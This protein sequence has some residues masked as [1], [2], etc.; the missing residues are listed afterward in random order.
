[1]LDRDW[2]GYERA[3]EVSRLEGGRFYCSL[4]RLTWQRAPKTFCAGVPV[5]RYGAWPEQLYTY[6]Q[7]RRDLHMRPLDREQPQG[8]Y[9]LRKSPYR[10]WLYSV[11]QSVPRRRMESPRQQ[12][13]VRKMRAGL[14]Q[15]YTCQRCGYYDESHGKQKYAREMSRGWCEDC[16]ADYERHELKLEQRAWAQKYREQ[17]A[18]VVLDSETTGLDRDDEVIEL[19]I[20]DGQ[21]GAVL[22]NSLIQPQ[23]INRYSLATHIHGISRDMLK[24]APRFPEVWPAIQEILRNYE[25]VLVYN[26]VFDYGMLE[27][28]AKRYGYDLPGAYGNWECLMH[29]YARYN[30]YWSNYWHGYG[31]CKLDDACRAMEVTS[32]GASHR[33]LGDTVRA[34]GVLNAMSDKEVMW[35]GEKPAPKPIDDFG[36]LEDCPF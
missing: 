35:E 26:A 18:F 16:R 10:R 2:T 25:R 21:T 14:V 11:E 12:E 19:G 23:D 3:H 31:W 7:L 34:L 36:D 30:G 17:G 4:C 22:F 9:F 33:A 28:T 13:A 1:M 27:A 15:R 32:D 24:E 8:A 29:Q 20:V 5:Y 6:T